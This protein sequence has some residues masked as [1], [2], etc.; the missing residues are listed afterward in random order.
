MNILASRLERSVPWFEADPSPLPW[1]PPE[2]PLPMP[3][4]T[5]DEAAPQDRGAPA[6]SPGGIA[7]RRLAVFG[8][9]ALLTAMIAI[10]P[11]VL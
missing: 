11:Y 10:G 9:A 7:R 8:G 1:L 3:R 6:T 2:S 4:Q 5:L